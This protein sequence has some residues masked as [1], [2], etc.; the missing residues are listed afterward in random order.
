MLASSQF[1]I[2]AAPNNDSSLQID[3]STIQSGLF[4]Y[5]T[6]GIYSKETIFFKNHL[7][8]KQ[9][10]PV[11]NRLATE[12]QAYFDEQIE[13]ATKHCCKLS[14]ADTTPKPTLDKNEDA[15]AFENYVEPLLIKNPFSKK[16]NNA[17]LT[18]MIENCSAKHMYHTMKMR[19]EFHVNYMGELPFSIN[20]KC[21][22]TGIQIGRIQCTYAHSLKIFDDKIEENKKILQDHDEANWIIETKGFRFA[23]AEPLYF[24]LPE[25]QDAKVGKSAKKIEWAEYLV[26]ELAKTNTSTTFKPRLPLPPDPITR[27]ILQRYFGLL[28]EH[29]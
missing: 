24:L 8:M 18:Q 15:Q 16:I 7:V 12:L 1:T 2:I 27:P 4:A 13:R 29:G 22:A 19:V 6:F 26:V 20:V 23:V 28:R 21:A 25:F 3:S 11:M 10:I 17:I 14:Q 9:T 5:F